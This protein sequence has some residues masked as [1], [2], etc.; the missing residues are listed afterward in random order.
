MTELGDQFLEWVQTSIHVLGALCDD[1][2]RNP[3]TVALGVSLC[4]YIY[5]GLD[6]LVNVQLHD[7]NIDPFEL[8]G[9]IPCSPLQ[10]GVLQS[11][12]GYEAAWIWKFLSSDGNAVGPHRLE[13]A[14]KAVVGVH[15][16]FSTI[17]ATHPVR[18]ALFKP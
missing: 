8:T 17:L 7:L 10:E 11:S 16:I 14:W 2:T 12:S 4:D 13:A 18:T 5:E 9:I 3:T 6:Y 15:K 1:L